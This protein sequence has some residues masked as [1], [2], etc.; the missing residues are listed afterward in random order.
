MDSNGQRSSF[1]VPKGDVCRFQRQET[2]ASVGVTKKICKKQVRQRRVQP[3]A[4]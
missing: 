2:S 4:S 3:R 1:T